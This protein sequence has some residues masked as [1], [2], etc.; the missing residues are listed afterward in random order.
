VESRVASASPIVRIWSHRNYAVLMAGMTP[1][2]LAIWMQRLGVGW[3][4][5]ELTHSTVWLGLVA[6]ADLAPM[7]VLA[8]LAGAVTDRGHALRQLRITQALTLAQAI[9]LV[10]LTLAGRM[11]IE[12]LFALS[13]FLGFLHPFA[14]AARH[15]IIPAT[16]PRS[17]FATA[18]ALDSAF[19]QAS[20]FVGPAIAG[21]LIPTVGIG[22]TFV[23]YA[24]GVAALLASLFALDLPELA[25]KTRRD[26]AIARDIRDGLAYVRSHAG[27]WPVFLLLSVVSVLVRPLQDMLPGFAGA[28]FDAGAV[29]LAWLTSSMGVGA[30]VSATWIATRGHT[31]GLARMFVFGLLGLA[32]SVLGFVAT[33]NLWLALPFAAWSGFALNSM[34]TSTQALVQ[35][36]V[37]DHMRG[38]VMSLYA[39]IFRGFP[40]VGTLA[41]GALAQSFGLRLTFALAAGICFLAWL[42]AAPRR[43][44]LA[45]GF[46]PPAVKSG[47]EAAE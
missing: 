8:F 30:M 21:V 23:A 16:V 2:L 25:D 22:G 17:F 4:A 41:I 12:L 7:L 18:V 5:W 14:S 45:R 37:A 20:R 1:N 36:A 3:L 39:L 33:D 10:A 46:D 47:K 40:A 29:G 31:R 19:F 35:T 9:V 28:V 43:G 32:F 34:S 11:T 6:A 44:A 26:S 24:A 38:R 13:L 27:I 15:S 42:M